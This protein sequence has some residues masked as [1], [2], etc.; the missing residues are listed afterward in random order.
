MTGFLNAGDN[1]LSRMT[2]AALEDMG[3]EVNYDAADAFGLPSALRLAELG[4]VAVMDGH[5]NHASLF[6]PYYVV[7]PRSAMENV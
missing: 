1:P 4:V 5:G 2:I 7:L 3:Y 6:S